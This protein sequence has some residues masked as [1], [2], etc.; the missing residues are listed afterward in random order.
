[1]LWDFATGF[2][3][4]VSS[5]VSC[6]AFLAIEIQIVNYSWPFKM[7]GNILCLYYENLLKVSQLKLLLLWCKTWVNLKIPHFDFKLYK[8][9][10]LETNHIQLL[11]TYLGTWLCQVT[12]VGQLKYASITFIRFG[13]KKWYKNLFHL[14][15]FF[16]YVCSERKIDRF[17]LKKMVKAYD[18]VLFKDLNP[19]ET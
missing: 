3:L 12:G 5:S 9:A 10:L 18:V 17:L 1:M 13:P 15:C 7:K 6:F 4:S 14:F 2:F 8:E 19:L 16:A 11:G